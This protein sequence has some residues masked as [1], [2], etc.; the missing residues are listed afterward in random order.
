MAVVDAAARET[1][2][3]R[4]LGEREKNGAFTGRYVVN[5]VNGEKLPVWVSDY[6]LMEYGTG[7]VMA[8]PSGD[9]RDFEF[10]RKYGLPIPPVVVA[11][12]DPLLGELSGVSERV[13]D[14]V[15]WAE[16]FAGDG[17]MVQ[18]GEFT[19]L[20]GGKNSEGMRAV[21]EWLDAARA[22][23][24]SRSTSDCATGSSAGSATGATRYPRF[25]VRP[26]D[27]CRCP[28]TSCP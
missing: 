6:V 27:S 1:A 3:E 22:W 9:Q 12:D 14:D 7:A 15:P 26:A 16:A 18:S 25:T 19:G 28:R 2:V 10:A 17:V 11:D 4:Q 13:R 24:G 8:V 20:R 5:P 21:T 23:A